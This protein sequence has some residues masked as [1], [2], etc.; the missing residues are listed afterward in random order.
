[1]EI[2]RGRE[3]EYRHYRLT[4]GYKGGRDIDVMEEG[5]ETS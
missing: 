1:M 2:G 4:V 3:N 5:R